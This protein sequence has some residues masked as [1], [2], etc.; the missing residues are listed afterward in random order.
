MH[1]V[2]TSLGVDRCVYDQCNSVHT[3]ADVLR[4]VLF[5]L[6]DS[7]IVPLRRFSRKELL[8]QMCKSLHACASHVVTKIRNTEPVMFLLSLLVFLMN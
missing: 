8:R 4:C 3:R 7:G 1:V 6:I 5:T 2:I